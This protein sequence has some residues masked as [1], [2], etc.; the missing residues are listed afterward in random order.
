MYERMTGLGF[1]RISC[2]LVHFSFAYVPIK[3]D[4]QISYCVPR[5]RKGR[6]ETWKYV[7]Q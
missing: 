4:L 7:L 3:L 6:K 1:G 2:S 5:R